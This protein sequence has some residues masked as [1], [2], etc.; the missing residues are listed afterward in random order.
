MSAKTDQICKSEI[1]L[2]CFLKAQD[3]QTAIMIKTV[4]DCLND[5]LRVDGNMVN[6][7]PFITRQINYVILGPQNFRKRLRMNGVIMY[8]R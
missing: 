4:S 8:S 1:K 7:V 6:I 5:N 2:T 3:P